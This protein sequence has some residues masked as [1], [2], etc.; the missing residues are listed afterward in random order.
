MQISL[1]HSYNR[2]KIAYFHKVRVSSKHGPRP[3]F[4]PSHFKWPSAAMANSLS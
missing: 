4:W 2:D 1:Y 3:P